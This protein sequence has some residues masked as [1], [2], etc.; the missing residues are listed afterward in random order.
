MSNLFNLQGKV[1]LVTGGSSGLGQQFARALAAQGASIAVLARRKERLDDFVKELSA[2]GTKC[3]AVRC[4]VTVEQNVIDAVAEVKQAFGRIDIL[5]N[6][7]GVA[8][9]VKAEE[10]SAAEWNKVIDANLNGVYMVARE[11]GKVMI[12]QKYGKIIN[13]GSVHSNT[14]IHGA[15]EQITAYCAS[16]GGVQMLTKA[17]AAEWAQH[18]ITV[19]A[20]GPA[21]FASEMT[22]AA[23]ESPEFLQFVAGRCPMGRLGKEGELDGVLLLFASDASSYI[24]GQLLN[25]DGGWNAI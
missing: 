18:N 19:N 13:I 3:L 14:V 4:D 20:I 22:Q 1:A 12:E 11:V 17:L 8:V 9:N 24:T 7:A 10:Q 6:N 25:V 2:A 23:T 15:V 16:K 21:Y 5:V